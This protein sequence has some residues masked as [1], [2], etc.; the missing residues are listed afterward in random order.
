[1]RYDSQHFSYIPFASSP[2]AQNLTADSG[3]SRYDAIDAATQPM[4]MTF[5]T[6]GTAVKLS[7]CQSKTQ[8]CRETDFINWFVHANKVNCASTGREKKQSHEGVAFS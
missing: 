1:M 7:I 6:D 2:Y 3:I 5:G 8:I 4:S